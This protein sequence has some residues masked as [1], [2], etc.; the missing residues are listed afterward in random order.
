VG[1]ERLSRD[2][3]ELADQDALF[4]VLAD[5]GREG[6]RWTL[7][8]FL[9]TGEREVAE[10]LTW[11]ERL[12]R[13]AGRRRALDFGSGV[14]RLTRPL[15]AH[16]DE[17]V[18][19]DISAEMVRRARDLNAD[20]PNCTLLHSVAPDLARFESGTFDLVHSSKVLQHMPSERLVC[21][22]VAEFMR[23]ARSDGLVAFQM[24]TR[25]PLR[26]RL[27]PRRRLYAA[28]RAVGLPRPFL[29]RRGLSP[30]GRGL[31]V[32]EALIRTTVE[33]RGGSVLTTRSDGEWGLW[34]YVAPPG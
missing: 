18:G 10:L 23:V 13:P 25:L 21:A 8:E 15:S 6:G 30:R 12:G 1:L 33:G 17:C 27:Q 14:G 32:P 19:V 11:A 3:D 4:V 29:A 24:W 7:D 31:S 26:N 28:L 16:F 5:P 34:Y 2:W 20:R 22:Y 9:A